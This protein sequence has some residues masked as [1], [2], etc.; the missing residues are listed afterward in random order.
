MNKRIRQLHRW[1]SI[2]FAGTIVLI[3]AMQAFGQ[4]VEWIYYLPL[5]PL[6]FLLITGLYLFALPYVPRAKAAH[7]ED[8]L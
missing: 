8:G 5:A 7:W 1:I 2:V 3:F 6:A 4:S